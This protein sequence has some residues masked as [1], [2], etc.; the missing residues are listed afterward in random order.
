MLYRVR[1][2]F[3]VGLLVSQQAYGDEAKIA[4]ELV[5]SLSPPVTVAVKDI[6]RG[7]GQVSAAV[8]AR[9]K[10]KLIN[11]IQVYGGEA[12]VKQVDRGKLE[13]ISREQ[14]EFQN[15]DDFAKIIAGAGA[16][17]IIVPSVTRIDSETVEISARALGVLENAAGQVVAASKSY[18]INAAVNYTATVASIMQGSKDRSAYKKYVNA[19]LSSYKE[20]SVSESSDGQPLDYTI[21]VVLDLTT[22][23]K[24]TAESKKAKHDQK[25]LAMFSNLTGGALNLGDQVDDPEAS[26]AIEMNVMV[27]ISMKNTQTGASLSDI[28]EVSDQIPKSS[29]KNEQKALAKSLVATAL[30]KAGQNI[31]AKALGK[32][33]T[34]G[35][36][37]GLLD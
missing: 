3:L 6:D 10:N 14:Q 22:V 27:E 7:Q 35:S 13:E 23:E 16:D 19:G 30:E 26:K 8:A 12:G 24:E 4:K 28:I 5:S 25:A 33:A 18:K 9:I 2:L 36:S 37:G 31:G 15:V 34:T 11:E 32:P 17:V 1:F 21:D 29:S 20:I